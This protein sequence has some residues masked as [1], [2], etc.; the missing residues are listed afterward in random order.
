MSQHIVV[1]LTEDALIIASSYGPAWVDYYGGSS[2]AGDIW[3][4]IGL[5]L[6]DLEEPSLFSRSQHVMVTEALE[7]GSEELLRQHLSREIEKYPQI[8]AITEFTRNNPRFRWNLTFRDF[9]AQFIEL[10]N[11]S[12]I[13]T[14]HLDKHTV[15]YLNAADGSQYFF[16][17]F[18]SSSSSRHPIEAL[19]NNLKNSRPV[20]QRLNGTPIN[21]IQRLSDL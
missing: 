16:Q 3:I 7:N 5:K 19:V 4:S 13:S 11:K 20:Y 21:C 2:G 9:R 8:E 17:T 1:G 6:D 12:S 10:L 14:R 15:G 18:P